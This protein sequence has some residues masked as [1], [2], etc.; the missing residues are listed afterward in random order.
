MVCAT[1]SP[2]TSSRFT[3]SNVTGWPGSGVSDASAS[4]PITTCTTFGRPAMSTEHLDGDERAYRVYYPETDDLS[5][6]FRDILASFG[7]PAKHSKN[8]A[9][10]SA[11]N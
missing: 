4:S 11:S 5:G 9:S 3:S 2:V 6:T 10:R 7:L 8:F 1:T